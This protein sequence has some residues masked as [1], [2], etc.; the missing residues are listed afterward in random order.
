M[1]SVEL[2]E[3]QVATMGMISTMLKHKIGDNV[4]YKNSGICRI[5]DVKKMSFGGNEEKM[6]YVLEPVY[7]EG[8]HTYVPA[9]SA[10]LENSMH[11]LL[12]KKQVQKAILD[13]LEVKLEWIQETKVRAV[14]FAEVLATYDRAKILAVIKCLSDYRQELEAKR[15]KMYA[16]DSKALLTAEKMIKDE[17]AFVLGI[18]R[19]EVFGYIKEFISK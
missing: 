7:A 13:S 4:I 12:D 19:E 16:S 10:T 8:S 6:Y 1:Y 9:D 18:K 2:T 5:C 14:Y 3:R 17:F 11:K 15:K